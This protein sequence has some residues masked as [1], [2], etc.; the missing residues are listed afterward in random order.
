GLDLLIDGERGIW[1]LSNGEPVSWAELARRACTLAG[2]DEALIDAQPA[3]AL[4]G[5]APQ[6]RYSALGSERGTL[7][8]TLDDALQRYLKSVEEVRRQGDTHVGAAQAAHY[9]SS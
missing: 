3:T 4:E 9:G 6:P 7:L 1:H 2:L 8:P 5:H